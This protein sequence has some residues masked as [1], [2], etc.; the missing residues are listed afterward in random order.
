MSFEAILWSAVN[1]IVFFFKWW[2]S[3]LKMFISSNFSGLPPQLPPSSYYGHHGS[4]LDHQKYHAHHLGHASSSAH[5]NGHAHSSH[6]QEQQQFS[7]FVSLVSQQQQQQQQQQLSEGI[8]PASRSPYHGYHHA[9]AAVGVTS[10]TAVSSASAAAAS[11]HHM[12]RP[13]ALR[14]NGKKTLSTALANYSGILWECR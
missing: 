14:T 4:S 3:Q 13:L 12:A 6:H 1:G 5:E 9:A 2:Y 10:T 7:D 11:A 8:H